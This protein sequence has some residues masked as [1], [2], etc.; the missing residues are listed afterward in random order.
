[1][2][3]V[4]VKTLFEETHSA[5]WRWNNQ[6]THAFWEKLVKRLRLKTPKP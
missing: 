5:E 1:M 3:I 6:S 4:R 2:V